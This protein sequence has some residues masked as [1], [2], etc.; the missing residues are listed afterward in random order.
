MRPCL[1]KS[2][3][4]EREERGREKRKECI[5]T[6]NQTKLHCQAKYQ[7]LTKVKIKKVNAAIPCT[8]LETFLN[9]KIISKINSDFSSS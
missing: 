6:D 4:G 9:F 1:K 2:S 3:E 7:Q 5:Y 8:R